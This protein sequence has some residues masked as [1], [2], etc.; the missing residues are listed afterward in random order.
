MTAVPPCPLPDLEPEAE[1][2]LEE[3]RVAIALNGGVS[4]AVWMGGCVVELDRVRRA[5][6]SQDTPRVYDALCRCLGRR[7]VVD[8]L[9]GTSAGGI[10]GG[11]LGAAMVKGR[12]LD[13]A[14]V[15]DRWIE[16]G[17]LAIL[18]HDADEES[19][20][21]LM[22]GKKFH[23]DLLQTFEG[24]LGNDEDAPGYAESAIP[25]EADPRVLVPSLDITMTDVR[26]VQRRFRDSWGGELVA[27]EHRPRF[28]F[29]E[30]EHFTGNALAAAARTTASFPV[31]FD[32]WHVQ[33]NARALADLPAATYGIDGGLLDNAPIREA[34]DLIPTRP[35]T[36]MV[37]RYFCYVNAD[38]DVSEEPTV[39]EPPTLGQVGGY[40]VHLP[41]Q[42]PLVDHLYAVRKAVERSGRSKRVQSEL[43][44][45][46]LTKLEAVAE[47]LFTSYTRRRTLESLE[48]LLPEPSDVNAMF[49][50][51]EETGGEL[52]W[53]PR[54]W[55]PGREPRWEWGLRPA[56]RILHFLLDLLRPAIEEA[57]KPKPGEGKERDQRRREERRKALL[58][59]RIDIDAQ[60]ARLGEARDHVTEPSNLDDPSHFEQKGV[61]QRVNDAAEAATTRS[62]EAREAVIEGAKAMRT[63]MEKNTDLFAPETTRA[64]F[65]PCWPKGG[66]WNHFLRRVLAIEVVRR[67]FAAEA[68]IESAEKLCFVQLT[69]D[70]PSPIFTAR[71]LRLSGPTSA[72]QKLTG[73]WLGHFAGFYR[74]S[75][76][77]NDY[78]WGRL[79]GAARVVDLLLDKPSGDVGEWVSESPEVRAAKRAKMLAEALLQSADTDAK[80]HLEEVM[81]SGQAQG[82]ETTGDLKAWLITTIGQEL[83][84]AEGPGDGGSLPVTRALFQRAAQIEVLR[85]ELSALREE[86]KKDHGLGSATKPLELGGKQPPRGLRD[87][88]DAV[89]KLYREDSSLPKKLTDPG[90]EVSNLGL[91]TVTHAFF[92]ALSALRTA[93]VPLAKPLGLARP[94]LLAIAGTVARS[95]LYRATVLAGFWAAA[96]FLTSCLVTA[97]AVQPTFA[98][99]WTPKT[100]AGLVAL[101]GV[102]GLAAVP[103]LRALRKVKRLRNA[104]YVIVL[105]LSGGGLA[106]ILA[107]T[108]GDLNV[109]QIVATP[110]A[111]LP[112]EWAIWGALAALGVASSGRL[113]GFTT[114]AVPV[115][116]RL[117]LDRVLGKIAIKGRLRAILLLIVFIAIGA[118]CAENMLEDLDGGLWHFDDEW[119][120]HAAAIT[121]LFVAPIFAALAVTLGRRN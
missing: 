82:K 90:E 48:E 57:G 45:T 95:R 52:P 24:I 97:E 98:S 31:A 102:A 78:M 66:R 64:L 114:R 10:N 109:E 111:K 81:R 112:S 23:R 63:C 50:L 25:A 2:K 34:L 67:A 16:L 83:L 116:G 94:P 93:K 20:T 70:A 43:L 53:I 92:V 32:P 106:V 80:W 40:M 55:R 13:P 60:L 86:S 12:R 77:V 46:D 58:Q 101:L 108:A 100:L 79:D 84:A 18:L 39:A 5:G 3:L 42:A 28:K 117:P 36:S 115:L 62:A 11:L 6:E 71:P 103:F 89:R 87:E 19:P 22:D 75:W 9:T 15:R 56:Q 107:A 26:G 119:W 85:D 113:L 4:L 104:F 99:V 91:Q 33:G 29:R 8:I 38:P 88:I 72:K 59:T 110:G 30:P 14:F 118:W 51:L 68:D 73:V 61:G 69:P 7:L 47:A 27:R 96:L 44:H 49:E 120:R 65:G 41:R 54:E 74:R 21:A 1:P 76:R 105:V 17:D 35:A 121:A 37:R